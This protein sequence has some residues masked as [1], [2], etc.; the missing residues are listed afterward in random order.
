MN[1][2]MVNGSEQQSEY[3]RIFSVIRPI[4]YFVE[5]ANALEERD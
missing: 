4:Q 3:V 2:S 1:G 5:R